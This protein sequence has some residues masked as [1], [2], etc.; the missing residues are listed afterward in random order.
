M[1]LI[2]KFSCQHFSNAICR[3]IVTGRFPGGWLLRRWWGTKV[4]GMCSC[5]QRRFFL[6]GSLFEAQFIFTFDFYYLMPPFSRAQVL[7]PFVLRILMLIHF[8]V[9]IQLL[10][11][12]NIF[13]T[14][15]EA[16][17]LRDWKRFN[18]I[19]RC[20]KSCPCVTFF[21][22]PLA[23]DA[24]WLLVTSRL[25]SWTERHC[26]IHWTYHTGRLG[27]SITTPRLSLIYFYLTVGSSLNSPWA[28][29]V[30]PLKTSSAFLDPGLYCSV[31]LCSTVA[32]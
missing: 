24:C 12:H 25:G 1:H 5:R 27:I 18:N 26:D 23:Y 14:S 11:V 4:V 9:V 20:C 17:K 21:S 13:I 8:A 22:Y 2:S 28:A 29:D 3:S 10:E 30:S 15:I 7:K 16:P 6:A 19:S 31:A 32:L